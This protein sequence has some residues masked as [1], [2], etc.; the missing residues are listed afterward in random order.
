MSGSRL[1]T[2]GGLVGAWALLV[3]L[4]GVAT[5]VAI[6]SVGA[7]LGEASP[8]DRAIVYANGPEPSTVVVTESPGS[9]PSASPTGVTS[10]PSPVPSTVLV[11]GPTVTVPGAP[12]ASRPRPTVT[13]TVTVTASPTSPQAGVATFAS[14]G[15]SVT[16]RCV[17]NT[18]R[19]VGVKPLSGWSATW[20]RSSGVLKVVFRSS[21]DSVR[22]LVA[23]VDGQPVRQ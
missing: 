1:R 13:R 18:P 8:A 14:R 11:P 5:W 22:I 7:G 17:E 3:A 6:S 9:S 15:G 12:P 10:S 20:E 16:V 23:C 21:G 2:V 19:I 4:A